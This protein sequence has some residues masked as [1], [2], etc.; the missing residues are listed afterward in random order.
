M[1]SMTTVFTIC[2]V[3]F[4][5]A[6]ITYIIATSITICFMIIDNERVDR[7]INNVPGCIVYAIVMLMI[8]SIV[9]YLLMS[10]FLL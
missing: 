3:A 5:A 7:V 9:T 10:H 1:I 2:S 4:V 8:D 6:V